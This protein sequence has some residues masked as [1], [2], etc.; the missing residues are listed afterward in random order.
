MGLAAVAAAVQD[1]GGSHEIRSQ[2]N[3]GFHLI[4][5]VPRP[6]LAQVHQAS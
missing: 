6:D 3:Q 1:L 4:I 5:R 2:K